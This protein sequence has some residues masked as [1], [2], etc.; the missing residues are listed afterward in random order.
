LVCK[1][2]GEVKKQKKSKKKNA[3]FPGGGL[4]ERGN[5]GKRG[6]TVLKK[7]SDRGSVERRS[8][9]R[10]AR[11]RA[12]TAILREDTVH[13]VTTEKQESKK[14]KESRAPE[15]DERKGR[16]KDTKIRWCAGARQRSKPRGGKKKLKR[17]DKKKGFEGG[18]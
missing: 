13:R 2:Y 12:S 1:Q 18:P 4:R 9:L 16:K 8:E 17:I 10:Q 6:E 14:E 7:G 3:H 11:K 5:I 15:A